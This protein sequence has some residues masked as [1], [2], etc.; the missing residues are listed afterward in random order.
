MQT[1]KVRY[2]DL[3]AQLYK[4]V[5]SG[6]PANRLMPLR[7]SLRRV[8]PIVLPLKSFNICDDNPSLI[9]VIT[10]QFFT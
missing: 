7:N 2:D 8:S 3:Q 6:L 10:P 1:V 4:V 5:S 9:N